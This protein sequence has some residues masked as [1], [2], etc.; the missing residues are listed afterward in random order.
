M[1]RAAFHF[2]MNSA[3]RRWG[4]WLRAIWPHRPNI[5]DA[6]GK[7]WFDVKEGE[8]SLFRPE[9][10]SYKLIARV[11]MEEWPHI[12]AAAKRR[13][14][15]RLAA[16]IATAA[17]ILLFVDTIMSPCHR[18][19]P[20]HARDVR[21][22]SWPRHRCPRLMTKQHNP[23]SERSTEMAPYVTHGE[24]TAFKSISITPNRPVV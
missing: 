10:G 6:L 24:I 17:A 3:H 1:P 11:Q 22:L 18:L 20:E 2:R 19:H 8:A 5:V 14:P 4:S 15:G 7:D 23:L 13:P 12:A 9:N 21:F 16:T